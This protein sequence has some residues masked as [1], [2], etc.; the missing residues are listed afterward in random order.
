MDYSGRVLV[1][2]RGPNSWGIDTFTDRNVY[3]KIGDAPISE[4]T[5]LV[6][7]DTGELVDSWGQNM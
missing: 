1:F 5:I 3:S 7:N 6:L 2:H 4:P